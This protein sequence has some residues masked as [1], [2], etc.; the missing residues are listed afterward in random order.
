MFVFSRVFGPFSSSRDWR[1]KDQQPVWNWKLLLRRNKQL[2]LDVLFSRLLHIVFGERTTTDRRL[3]KKLTSFTPICV[4]LLCCSTHTHTQY[5]L[6]TLY[7]L[8]SVN[9]CPDDYT[10]FVRM[11]HTHQIGTWRT[12]TNNAMCSILHSQCGDEW[13]EYTVSPFWLIIKSFLTKVQTFTQRIELKMKNNHFYL[14]LS[15]CSLNV[16]LIKLPR[17]CLGSI[18]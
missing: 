12:V 17:T 4:C 15:Y 18:F 16:T 8:L 13:S 7:E 14:F 6:C 5:V 2:I 3:V 10:A 11:C 9:W 1:Q